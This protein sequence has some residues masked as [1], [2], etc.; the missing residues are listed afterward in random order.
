M[1]EIITGTILVVGAGLAGCGGSS[2]ILQ[3]SG[4]GTPQPLTW[5]CTISQPATYPD[6]TTAGE[7]ALAELEA[8]NTGSSAQP[9]GSVTVSF[10]GYGQTQYGNAGGVPEITDT[11]SVTVPA[12]GTKAAGAIRVNPEIDAGPTACQVTKWTASAPVAAP[13]PIASPSP[14]ALSAY[15]LGEAFGA[16]LYLSILQ[17]ST[18]NGTVSP[19][20]ARNACTTAMDAGAAIGSA[21]PPPKGSASWAPFYQGCLAAFGSPAS[22]APSS[23]PPSSAAAVSLACKI[24]QEGNGAEEFNI[25]TAGGGTYA[26][27][28]SVA[29][30]DYAGSGHVFAGTTVQGASPAGRWYA[31]PAADIGAT[32]EPSGCTA[33]AGSG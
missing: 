29:F 30:Y 33:T 1:R 24:L 21:V 6:G 8:T 9:V 12:N 7:P 32:A 11:V 27:T 31:V 26:G 25:S 22:A 17:Q 19:A 16:P 13:S 4:S 28:V 20:Q 10:S 23:P 2:V 15:Q 14:P 18:N 3:G 5:T